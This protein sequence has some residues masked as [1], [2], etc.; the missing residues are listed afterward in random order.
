MEVF[1]LQ[2]TIICSANSRSPEKYI[3]WQESCDL[4]PMHSTMED[5]GARIPMVML[6]WV[7][8]F[9]FQE[10]FGMHA[11]KK[12]WKTTY[13]RLSHT[14][15]VCL[16]ANFPPNG[17]T[18]LSSD[19]TMAEKNEGDL[20]EA[21]LNNINV[22][23]GMECICMCACVCVWVTRVWTPMLTT[24]WNRNCTTYDSQLDLWVKT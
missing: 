11:E 19:Y 1:K 24:C 4:E 15:G 12:E 23:L 5:G 3:S 8:W 14:K 9:Q 17:L 7:N 2:A 13:T 21:L 16:D 22:L 10:K 18:E 6:S 20:C